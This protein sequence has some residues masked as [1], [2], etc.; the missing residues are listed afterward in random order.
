M[1]LKPGLDSYLN[2]VDIQ[3]NLDHNYNIVEI[4]GFGIDG[5]IVTTKGLDEIE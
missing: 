1:R 3:L 4:L 2:E 5:K